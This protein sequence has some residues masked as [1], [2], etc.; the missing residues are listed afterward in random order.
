M[1]NLTI[2][3][4]GLA[5]NTVTNPYMDGVVGWENTTA[6]L[7]GNVEHRLTAQNGV[8]AY[9]PNDTALREPLRRGLFLVKWLRWPPFFDP[10]VIQVSKWLLEEMVRGVSGLPDNTLSSIESQFGVVKQKMT[11][12]GIY[13]EGGT[14]LTIKVPEFAG[15]PLR[16]LLRYWLYGV[17]D[18]RTGV[19]HFY[20]RKLRGVQAN[21]SG[22]L[23]YVLLGPTARPDDI[24]YSCIIHNCMPYTDKASHLSG[25][26]GDAGGEE[27]WD[28]EL[29]GLFDEGPEVDAL[30][31]I[32]VQG[33]G[34]YGESFLDSALPAYMYDQI[35]AN[36]E[37]PAKM[38]EYFS[39]QSD[40]KRAVAVE[41]GSDLNN[42]LL[43][44]RS[45]FRI[46]NNINPIAN[47]LENQ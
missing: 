38:A 34:L 12:S 39:M 45:N 40:L 25:D 23:I 8:Q 27:L 29:K 14:G 20:G 6:P 1:A 11:T 2:N 21:R 30:A 3:D 15:S 5:V 10:K 33:Y 17:S 32:I 36:K 43:N 4:P 41:K 22:T 26:I 13:E 47:P 19:N 42:E 44:L 18:K 46:E 31:K 9:D 35:I 7:A 16:K 37:D 28:I 24:E